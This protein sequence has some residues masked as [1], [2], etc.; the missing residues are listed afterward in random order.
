MLKD[1][2]WL[3]RRPSEHRFRVCDNNG[4]NFSAP[5]QESTL[6]RQGIDNENDSDNY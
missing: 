3:D 5:G 6:V 4:S 1:R 2:L